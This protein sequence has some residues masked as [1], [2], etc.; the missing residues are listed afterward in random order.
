MNKFNFLFILLFITISTCSF[1]QFGGL[2]KKIKKPKT[3]VNKPTTNNITK[4]SI[5]S[6]RNDDGSPKHDSESPIYKAYAK[7]KEGLMF[8]RGAV[9]GFEAKQDPEKA[10]ADAIKYLAKTKEHLDF[11]NGESSEQNREYLAAFNTE[12]KRL[13]NKHT[14]K[15]KESDQIKYHEDRLKEYQAWIVSGIELKSTDLEP[16]VRGYKKTRDAFKN[17]H[18]KAFESNNVKFMIRDVEDFFETKV[19]QKVK[20]LDDD[21]SRTIK[22]MYEVRVEQEMYI[23]NADGYLEDLKEPLEKLAYYKKDLLED[24]TSANA[25]EAKINKETTMLEDYINSGKFAANVAKYEK[26]IID[27]RLL[28]KGMSDSQIESFAKSKLPA[29]YGK[30]LRVT[31][32]STGWGINK[33]AFDI[34]TSKGLTVDFAVKKEDG[35]CYYM[36]ATIGKTYEGGGKYGPMWFSQ[37]HVDG[38]MNCNNVTKNK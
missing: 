9:E 2:I 13:E 1:G 12:Y 19:Y 36:R 37:P 3:S 17:A 8:A 25:L 32:A 26:Q 23:L 28:R 11:L 30:V 6:N 24:P 14:S 29:K 16:T 27:G 15:S 5:E 4:P 31:V 7:V 21:I 18:P 38:E 34:P 20:W 22:E 33:N 35:K 10:R